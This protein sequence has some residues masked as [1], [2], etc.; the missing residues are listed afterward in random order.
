LQ[1]LRLFRSL[2]DAVLVYPGERHGQVFMT[3][4]GDPAAFLHLAEAD[5]GAEGRRAANAKTADF[6]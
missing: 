4:R 6:Q 3:L 5:A 1:R 2:I